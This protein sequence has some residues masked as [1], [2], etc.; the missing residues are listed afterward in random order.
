MSRLFLSRPRSRPRLRSQ[1]QEQDHGSNS[2]CGKT[3]TIFVLRTPRGLH[4]W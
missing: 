1:T 4:H 3:K 2:Q